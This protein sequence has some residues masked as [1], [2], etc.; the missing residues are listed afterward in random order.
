MTPKEI[1]YDRNIYYKEWTMNRQEAIDYVLDYFNFHKVVKQM[2]QFD[3]W[4][5]RD[6]HDESIEFK[7]AMCRQWAR[8]Y[9]NSVSDRAER[10]K[11]R[12]CCTSTGCFEIR[13]EVDINSDYYISLKYVGEEW[14]NYI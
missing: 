12:M 2:D 14:D 4:L 5:T 9:I 7:V 6:A 1:K 10:D 11:N 8:K 3:N 13:V